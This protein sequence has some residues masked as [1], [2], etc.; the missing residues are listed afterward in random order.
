MALFNFTLIFFS[1]SLLL[2]YAC[3]QFEIAFLLLFVFEI[4]V[5]SLFLFGMVISFLF[6]F[7]MVLFMSDSIPFFFSTSLI[8]YIEVGSLFIRS[9]NATVSFRFDWLF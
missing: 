9:S 3:F 1:S 8:F 2:F 5:V 7:K 4:V 6:L